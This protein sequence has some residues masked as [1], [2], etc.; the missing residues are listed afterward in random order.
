MLP[1]AAVLV[2]ALLATALRPS[3]ATAGSRPG[4][5]SRGRHAALA[6]SAKPPINSTVVANSSERGLILNPSRAASNPLQAA[7]S[8]SMANGNA[9]LAAGNTLL[10]DGNAL[11]AADNAS[12]ADGNVFQAA[13]NTWAASGGVPKTACNNTTT[14]VRDGIPQTGGSNRHHRRLRKAAGGAAEWIP[15]GTQRQLAQVQR[16]DAANESRPRLIC[17]AERLD[18]IRALPGKT[19]VI[20]VFDSRYAE[21][22]ALRAWQAKGWGI[23]FVGI[24]TEQQCLR[25]FERACG[26][27]EGNCSAIPLFCPEY[28]RRMYVE[29]WIKNTEHCKGWR[30]TQFHKAFALNDVMQLGKDV[31]LIDTDI[32]LGSGRALQFAM[33]SWHEDIMGFKRDRKGQ[34]NFGAFFARSTPATRKVFSKLKHRVRH[35]WDQQSFNQLMV[36]SERGGELRCRDVRFGSKLLAFGWERPMQEGVDKDDPGATKRCGL[37]SRYN[38]DVNMGPKCKRICFGD[39][40]KRCRGQR[41]LYLPHVQGNTTQALDWSSG[42]SVVH[43]N[44]THALGRRWLE[45]QARR[46]LQPQNRR[47]TNSTPAPVWEPTAANPSLN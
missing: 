44:T 4:L 3:S 16:K 7:G 10:A 13:G 22:G 12:M 47:K 1:R 27:V 9:S 43:G 34:L 2:L 42:V 41:W 6:R 38:I 24:C 18:A 35:N 31:L 30:T 20:S 14:I 17:G 26:G 23:P 39:G 19:L 45:P 33:R 32:S 28:S 8:A 40:D 46:H 29:P 11:W 21:A 37:G 25:V 36:E 15:A 5:L